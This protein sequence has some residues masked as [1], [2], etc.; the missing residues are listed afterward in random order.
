MRGNVLGTGVGGLWRNHFLG[1]KFLPVGSC[2]DDQDSALLQGS[3]RLVGVCL[4]EYDPTICQ[5]ML[6]DLDDGLW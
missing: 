4:K 6:P 1:G 3:I 2:A 5:N